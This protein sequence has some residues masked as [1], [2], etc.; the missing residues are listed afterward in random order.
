MPQLAIGI[1]MWG[2]SLKKT[3]NQ[4]ALIV[5]PVRWIPWNFVAVILLQI[6]RTQSLETIERPRS[7][8]LFQFCFRHQFCPWQLKEKPGQFVGLQTHFCQKMFADQSKRNTQ[9][10]KPRL[11]KQKP[12]Q[13]WIPN[14]T[15]WHCSVPMTLVLVFT[16]E[17]KG[18]FAISFFVGKVKCL[19]KCWIAKIA[20]CAW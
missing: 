15:N 3:T 7:H 13:R 19:A 5:R 1:Q 17:G 20:A 11:H 14:R 2:G 10:K 8:C 9:G 18:V 16:L 4:S 6:E 12:D